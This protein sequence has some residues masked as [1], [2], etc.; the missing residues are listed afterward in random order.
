MKCRCCRTRKAVWRT[1]HGFGAQTGA[2]VCDNY[3]CRAWASNGYP[4]SFYRLTTTT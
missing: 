2:K 3:A 1:G 4:V